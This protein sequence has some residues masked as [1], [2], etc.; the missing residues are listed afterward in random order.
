MTDSKPTLIKNAKIWMGLHN[1]KQVLEVD[2]LIDKG[3]LMGAGS[4]G[5][6]RLKAYGSS[7]EVVDAHS[8]IRSLKASWTSILIWVITC[9]LNSRALQPQTAIG[10]AYPWLG[11]LDGLNTHDNANSLSIAG[12]MTALILPDS[13]NY[14]CVF[15]HS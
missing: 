2:I 12:V 15:R 10:T 3:L 9:R 13:A 6:S 1:G 5:Y 7:L 4:F 14:I 8:A 11:S